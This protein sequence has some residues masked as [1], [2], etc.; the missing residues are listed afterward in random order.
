[1]K[2]ITVTIIRPGGNDTA[3]IAGLY[4][5][6]ERRK[7]NKAILKKYPTVE[8]VGF[9]YYDKQ[10]N[11]AFLEMAGGEFCGNASRSLA[12]LLIN[13]SYGKINIQSSGT[14]Q[15][16]KSGMNRGYSYT[17]IPASNLF[18][19]IKKINENIWQVKLD[20]I[21]HLILYEKSPII[22]T[23]K[24]KKY[25]MYLL[26]KTHLS[27]TEKAAGVMIVTEDRKLFPIVW[28]RD[29][30][31]LFLETS[32]ASGTS[33]VAALELYKSN[34]KKIVTTLIQPS[35]IPLTACVTMQGKKSYVETY[36]VTTFLLKEE[37]RNPKLI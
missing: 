5:V 29:I 25:G 11:L 13:S 14:T 23:N 16:I 21:T 37:M 19:N 10:K 12:Y 28:V 4:S 15:I 3:L 34:S 27:K 35:T 20:G 26:H 31:T 32:C 33:A 6:L 8:Q 22:D 1:M 36:G 2:S 18:E 7:I 24:M 17:Q 9:Y 30:Q